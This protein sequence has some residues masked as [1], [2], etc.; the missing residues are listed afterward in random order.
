MRAEAWSKT[1]Q[2]KTS[3][4]QHKQARGRATNKKNM[5]AKRGRIKQARK[6][7]KAKQSKG[8]EKQSS[9]PASQQASG[10]STPT[11][12]TNFE[13]SDNLRASQAP[14]ACLDNRRLS[15]S[16]QRRKNNLVLNRVQV[17]SGVVACFG[18]HCASEHAKIAQPSPSSPVFGI[19]PRPS[20]SHAQLN[21]LHFHQRKSRSEF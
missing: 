11:P 19:S 16:P 8:K 7:A 2:S 18:E 17:S 12:P 5:H 14:A 20:T 13:T 9:K 1:N 10:H 4:D 6:Q 3:Q 15:S 21:G